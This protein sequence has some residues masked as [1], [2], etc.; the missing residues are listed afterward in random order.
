M[1][2]LAF[3]VVGEDKRKETMLSEA[4]QAFIDDTRLMKRPKT[5]SQ[6]KTALE[7][8]Q[9]SCLDKPLSSVDLTRFMG[10]LA[11][12]KNW[13]AGRSGTKYRWSFPC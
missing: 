5:H 6:Y 13:R 1:R 8:F 12:Q 11:E 7:Y 3:R 9:E 4:C 2:H 10:F